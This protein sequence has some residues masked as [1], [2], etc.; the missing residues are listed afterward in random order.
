MSDCQP[1]ADQY[2]D[3]IEARGDAAAKT[4]RELL[5]PK[6]DY[7]ELVCAESFARGFHY[8]WTEPEPYAMDEAANV[9]DKLVAEVRRLRAN[10]QN[11]EPVRHGRWNKAYR[12]GYVPTDG[13]PICSECDCWNGG[14]SDYCP[15]CGAKMDDAQKGEPEHVAD[16]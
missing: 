1:I 14:K 3:E 9:I 6:Q 16:V 5:P 8:V 2:L 11:A 13:K 12:S 4:L 10:V 7:A 15:H